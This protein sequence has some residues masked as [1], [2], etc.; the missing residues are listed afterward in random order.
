RRH[1][2]QHGRINDHHFQLGGLAF[3][4]RRASETPLTSFLPELEELRIVVAHSTHPT[5]QIGSK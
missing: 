3:I 1:L 4:R 2:R 5:T